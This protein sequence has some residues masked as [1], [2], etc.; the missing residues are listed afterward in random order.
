MQITSVSV[1]LCRPLLLGAVILLLA[2]IASPTHLHRRRHRYHHRPMV[3]AR[4]KPHHFNDQGRPIRYSEFKVGKAWF[5]VVVANIGDPEVVASLTFVKGVS[6][7]ATLA[8]KAGACAALTGTFFAPRSGYPVGDVLVDGK[9]EAAGHRGSALAIDYYGKPHVFD[10]PYGAAV[11]WSSYRWGLRG[12]VRVLRNRRIC[13]NPKG[14][15][16]RDS[17]IW[18]RVA[19]AGA[20]VSTSGKLVLIAT[21]Y[22]VTLSE[23]G[24]AMLKAGMRDAVSLDGGSST[25]LLYRGVILINPARKL[26][27]M[28][29][30]AEM[31]SDA[32]ST[33]RR[34]RPTVR[35][36]PHADYLNQ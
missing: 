21:R 13:P 25:C 17:R 36:R 35:P 19:R 16:F 9:L 7:P 2:C 1:N 18:S 15:H 5:H 30:L 23:L 8:A 4:F 34:S 12:S 32:M 33:N 6:S 26:S 31:G 27:N 14:Q 29:V 3:L 28:L 20:G 22:P 24:R 10:T 11:D